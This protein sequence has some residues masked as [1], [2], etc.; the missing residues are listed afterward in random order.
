MN[1]KVWGDH[2][3]GCELINYSD[4][5]TPQ[6]L[7]KLKQISE[8]KGDMPLA[9][10]MGAEDVGISPLVQKEI[11]SFYKIPIQN[12]DSYNVSVAT[13]LTLYQVVLNR[14]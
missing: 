5:W 4:F 12:I 1:S 14:S 7:I 13:A 3:Y 9:L 11:T 8:I 2:N 6:F 10:V